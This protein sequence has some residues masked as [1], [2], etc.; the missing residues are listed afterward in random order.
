M[1]KWTILCIPVFCLLWISRGF[2]GVF[3]TL[4]TVVPAQRAELARVVFNLQVMGMDSSGAMAALD[5]LETMAL[6]EENREMEIIATGL[7]GVYFFYR[8]PGSYEKA[9]EFLRKSVLLAEKHGPDIQLARFTHLLGYVI[10]RSGKYAEGFEYMLKADYM[11][12][13]KGYHHIEGVS[14]Y[15]YNIARVYGDFRNHS[16][17]LRYL[18]LALRYS[19]NQP[20][21]VFG[22]RNL[23]GIAAAELQQTEQSILHFTQALATAQQRG[24]S[25]GMGLSMSNLG[26]AWLQYGQPAYALLLLEKGYRLTEIY[27]VPENS[28]SA[29]LQMTEAYLLQNRIEPARKNINQ[30]FSVIHHHHVNDLDAHLEYYRLRSQ[31]HAAQGEYDIAHVYNDSANSV[32]DS[33]TIQKDMSMLANMAAQVNAEKY[34]ADIRILEQ[35]QRVRQYIQKLIATFSC[36]VFAVLATLLFRISYKRKKEQSLFRKEQQQS[37]EKLSRFREHIR[38]KNRLIEQFKDQ[39][40][41][42]QEQHTDSEQHRVNEKVLDQ[43]YESIILTE[44]DWVD[45]KRLFENVYPDFLSRLQQQHSSLTIAEIRLLALMKMNLSVTEMAGMLGILPQSVRKTRQRLMKKL[46]IEDHKKLQ[47]FLAEI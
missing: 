13:R 9:R 10:Y 18:D 19:G 32:R 38:E 22:I 31:L 41:Y 24:D 37:E 12:T 3:D 21:I 39:V 15:L 33:I 30:A 11:M 35:E 2:C 28:V 47:P 46:Q 8:I 40:K 20:G 36:L 16:Q 4:H 23:M 25:A 17:S 5:E 43:L 26:G 14:A 42:Y 44:D 6:K 1:K 7:R 34:Q 27:G 29:L 45:F